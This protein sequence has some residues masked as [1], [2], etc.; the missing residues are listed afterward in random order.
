M[1][2]RLTITRE[3]TGNINIEV[4]DSLSRTAFVKLTLT[5]HDFAMCLTGLSETECVMETKHMDRVGK[6]KVTQPRT[7]HCRMDTHNRGALEEWLKE[8][9]QEDGWNLDHYLGSSASITS[10]PVTEGGGSI[11]KYSV[12]KWVDA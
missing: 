4:R 12:S 11:L 6:R 10:V 9:C 7:A 2:G 5:P 1:N 8:H 3:S